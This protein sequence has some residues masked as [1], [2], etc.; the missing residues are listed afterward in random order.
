MTP[1]PA[2]PALPSLGLVRTVISLGLLCVL[3]FGMALPVAADAPPSTAETAVEAYSRTF[4]TPGVA[5]A[6]IDDGEIET[7][8]TG[9]D[10]AGAA[11]T[12]ET[13]FR[14]ASMSKSMTA[15]AIMILV[16]DGRLR[17]DDRVVDVLPEFVMADAR[18]A[19]ITIRQLLSH[20]SGLSLRTNDEYAL[21]V[22]S[23]TAEVVAELTDRRLAAAPGEVFEYHNTNYSL[24]G[25]IVE[26]VSGTS[27]ARFLKDR[28]FAP[29]GM[30]ASTS[31]DEC[32]DR[33]D[34]LTDGYSVVLGAAYT[35]PEMP[36]RCGGNG[37]VVST[38][39]DMVRWVRFNQGEIGSELLRADLLAA[40]HESQPQAGP[41]ALGW[42][43]YGAG[44]GYPEP[45]ITHGGTLATFTGSMAFA[46]GTGTAA[47]VLTNGVGSPGV[48]ATNL[49]AGVDGGEQV[50]YEQPLNLV[51][52]ILLA[53]AAL[54]ALLLTA[55]AIRAPRWVARR[56]AARRPWT[57]WR[58]LPLLLVIPAGVFV[59]LLPG[60]LGGMI[61]WQ[62]WVIDFWLLPLLDV[63]GLVLI[64]GGI[65]ALVSR[66]VMLRLAPAPSAE[67]AT[68]V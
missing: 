55:T 63:L 15:T 37:G 18:H 17:L 61:S 21:P 5:A 8:L 64:L 38:L 40:L 6:V 4:A 12:S 35:L 47:V 66:I 62:Y 34:G 53:L 44:D 51:N 26:V 25:R 16:Q 57:V 42:E 9:R 20:T 1:V 39:D 56:R 14:I 22:P 68:V 50:P 33:V 19:E 30:R 3:V 36:G 54:C 28:V 24:A 32:D 65:S 11:V 23:T 59:P 49:I 67:S 41:Y 27:L 48:L 46:P 13:P 31:V 7:V 45:I 52:G 29:L 2:P 58:T 60:L 10:G 43:S